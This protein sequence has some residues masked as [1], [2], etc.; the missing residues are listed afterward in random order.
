MATA[1]ELNKAAARTI[2][3]AQDCTND[4]TQSESVVVV[5]NGP[6]GFRF[7]Q[8][9]A[10]EQQLHEFQVCVFGEERFPAYDRVNLTKFLEHQSAEAL[11]YQGREWYEQHLIELHTNDPVVRIDRERQV[12]ESLSGRNVRYD[13]LVL[14][15]GS[16]PF[17]PPIAGIDLDGV[18]PYRTIDDLNRIREYSDQCQRAVVIGGGL[19][20]LEAAEA[21][22]RLG[23][24]VVVVEMA[25]ALMPRQLDSAGAE[26]LYRELEQNGFQFR[27]QRTSDRFER[28]S[29]GNLV[30]HFRNGDT[31]VTDMIVVSA[32]IRPRDELAR[33]CELEIGRHGG[34]VVDDTLQ[35]S[36][37][38]IYAIGE[39]AEHRQTVYGLVAP[40]FQMASVLADRLRGTDAAFPGSNEA[41]RL[42]LSGVNVVFFGDYL[43]RTGAS[44]YVW[45]TQSAYVRL[46]VRRS[47]L[48]GLI[49]VGDVSA[50]PRLQ[51][52]IGQKRFAFSWQLRRFEN[53]GSMSKSKNADNI[54][55]W[56]ASTIV[57]TC[58]NVTR[59]CLSQARARGCES[60]ADIAR[61]TSATTVCGSCLPLVQQFAGEPVTAEKSSRAD[62]ALVGCSVAGLVLAVLFLI[63][64]PVA[65]LASVQVQ[66]S[67]WQSLL[68]NS[69]WKQFTG[70]TALGLAV[71]SLVFSLRKRKQ[72]FA[73][74]FFPRVSVWSRGPG[75][76]RSGH[77]Y[78]SHRVA[79]RQQS[80]FCVVVDVCGRVG[81][82]QPAGRGCGL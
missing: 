50:L 60:V 2:D 68:L 36:D 56:P 14:A 76:D 47:R 27:M 69:F 7:L 16:R 30:V 53:S 20:G 75:G 44:T 81:F 1:S 33:D 23:L 19:L 15:T 21:L 39:C 73:R 10:N 58:R 51:T 79:N 72:L 77:R 18:F 9:L 17:M 26:L 66:P 62:V 3:R 25:A 4:R 49:A 71:L 5:G 42:K 55:N 45:K 74:H 57:C 12:V 29:S 61:E 11:Q 22:Q 48:V 28:D 32:G 64:T 8:L 54:A 67:F 34:I 78:C 37:P 82:G 63:V 38:H 40:G 59:G 35:S 41:T 70:Y 31:C 13:R 65:P 43:D 46:F 80:E 6:V 24:E 52:A